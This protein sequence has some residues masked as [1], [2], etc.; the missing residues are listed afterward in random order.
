MLMD[1]IYLKHKKSFKESLDLIK[2]NKFLLAEQ[3][4]ENIFSQFPERISVLTNL[5]AVKIKLKKFDK[6]EELIERIIEIDPVNKDARFNQALLLGEKGFFEKSLKHINNFILT[7]NLDN[8]YLSEALSYRGVLYSKLGLFKESIDQHKKAV[9]VCSTNYVAKWNLGLSYLLNGD[10][11]NGFKLYEAR[12]LKNNSKHVNQ[13][14]SLSEIKNKKIL[15][16]AEQGFGDVIQFARYIPLLKNYSSNI[17]FL[18]PLELKN[19]FIFSHIDIV[20]T[21]NQNDYDYVVPLMSLP[22]IFK[23]T[24]ESIP[25]SDYLNFK[26][27]SKKL[28]NDKIKI[29]LAWSGR[30]SYPYDFLRSIPL[31]KLERLYN[32]YPDKFDFY[33]LQKDIRESDKYFFNKSNIRYCGDKSFFDIANLILELDLVI[34]SDTSILHLASSLQVKTFGLIPFC[35]DWR[36]LLNISTSPWYSKLKLFRCKADN[37]WDNPIIDVVDNLSLISN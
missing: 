23:T 35:P 22:Y 29:G 7:K 34:S 31:Q 10:F 14:H 1:D 25:G 36:W 2:N 33:C 19:F 8:I 5:L 21:F 11:E 9:Q 3:K 26:L 13:I 32:L 28:I 4:L 16:L 30:E 6:A 37:N 12:F 18:P 20:E 15:V 24:L 27:K 17:H